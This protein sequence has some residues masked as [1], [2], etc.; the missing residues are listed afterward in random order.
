MKDFL[1]LFWTTL[2]C[3]YKRR[4]HTQKF[5]LKLCEK[6]KDAIDFIFQVIVYEVFST[7]YLKSQSHNLVSEIRYCFND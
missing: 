6:D 7:L 3:Y 5:F 2:T 1:P 4:D